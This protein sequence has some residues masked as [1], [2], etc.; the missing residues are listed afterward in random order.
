MLKCWNKRH[1]CAELR[2]THGLRRRS[3]LQAG[4]LRAGGLSLAELL[5]SEARA[6]SDNKREASVIILWMR[7]GPS[8]I[9][10]WDPK[11]EAPVEYRGEFGSMGTSV[12]G[13]ALTD[14]L[15]K[16]AAIMQKW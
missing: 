14:M 16:S 8:H 15:P 6:G 3:F 1:G 4:L 12:P 5:R 10:M 2:A 9:D 7:G 13:I 11:P